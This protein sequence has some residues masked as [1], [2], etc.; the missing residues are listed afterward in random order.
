MWKGGN[1]VYSFICGKGVIMFI[2]LYVEGG[3]F[4]FTQ[5]FHSNISYTF[6]VSTTYHMRD[7]GDLRNLIG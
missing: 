2:T 1:N 4:K 7:V 3:N 6:N 5:F